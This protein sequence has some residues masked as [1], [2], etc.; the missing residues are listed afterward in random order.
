MHNKK[1]KKR[2]RRILKALRE[3][4]QVTYK[5]NPIKTIPN[6]SPEIMKAIISRA[7]VIQ[8]LREKK[9]QTRLLDASKN[10]TIDWENKVFCEKKRYLHNMLEQIQPIKW[11]IMGKLQ[12][13]EGN[14]TLEK[15]RNWSWS[16]PK[17][18]KL[19]E[20]H[21]NSNNKNNRKQQLLFLNIS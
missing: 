13:K 3:N 18:R 16:K 20:S 2:K 19:H 17:R 12:Y 15:P 5:G 10:F 9:C 7:D 6:L 11:V 1:K 21:S 8:T 14:Y 4:G